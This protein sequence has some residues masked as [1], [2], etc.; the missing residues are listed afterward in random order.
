MK[1]TF[2][3]ASIA[4]AVLANAAE[5][6]AYCRTRTC[7][8]DDE[9]AIRCKYDPVTRCSTVGEEV[10]WGETCLPY[11]IQEDGS[12]AEGI[13]AEQL[14]RTVADGFALWTTAPCTAGGT[15]TFSVF[16]RG[17]IACDAFEYNCEAGDANNNIIMFKDGPSTLDSEQLAL[18]I[19]TANL[20]TGEIF[21]VDVLINSYA[22]DFGENGSAEADL[23]QVIN[24]E[25]GHFLGLSHTTAPGALMGATYGGNSVPEDDDIAGICDIYDNSNREPACNVSRLTPDA[26]CV[27]TV[28][29]CRIQVE[30]T[31]GEGC[32]CD[33]AGRPSRAGAWSAL[34]LVALAT[35]LYR[36][37]A[38][39]T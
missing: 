16:D 38:G 3:A 23:S 28:G 13:T 26:E 18:S 11:A 8:F 31:E 29:V 14:R 12:R 39:A 21:D 17:N 37:R 27:G 30:G 5:S 19:L 10:F 32:A 35:T 9:P 24:H 15:P 33:V 34:A 7:E 4:A 25:L 22:W 2:L 20:D 36:R 1:S 6:A